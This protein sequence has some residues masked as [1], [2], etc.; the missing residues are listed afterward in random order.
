M[1]WKNEGQKAPS[2]SRGSK[3]EEMVPEWFYKKDEPT[4]EIPKAKNPDIEERRRK[5]REEL[6]AKRKGV[7]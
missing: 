3:R 7:K 5:L 1:Q 2:Y 4:K 6:N